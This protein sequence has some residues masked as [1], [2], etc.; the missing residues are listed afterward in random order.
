MGQHR[1]TEVNMLNA[2]LYRPPAATEDH[3]AIPVAIAIAMTLMVLIAGAVVSHLATH[4]WNHQVDFP[5]SDWSTNPP[6]W[7]D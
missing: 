1:Y 7:T 3:A 2:R 5:P 4:G 6:N